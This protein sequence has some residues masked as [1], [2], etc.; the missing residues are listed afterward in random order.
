MEKST[1]KEQNV[2]FTSVVTIL[3][4]DLANQII[5]DEGHIFSVSRPSW[6]NV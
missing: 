2:E 3:V 4:Q 5:F 6:L 1:I